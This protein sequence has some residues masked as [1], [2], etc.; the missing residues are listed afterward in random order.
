MKLCHRSDEQV[1][2]LVVMLLRWTI[3]VVI[4]TMSSTLYNNYCQPEIDT[5]MTVM[6]K[7]LCI[8]ISF[9][10]EAI[11]LYFGTGGFLR[12]STN[13]SGV[14][15]WHRLVNLQW[16]VHVYVYMRMQIKIMLICVMW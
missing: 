13:N 7:S 2:L 8:V 3:M 1:T 12:E 10:Y 6:H 14:S 9:F 4:T 15:N 16:Y 5:V 11:C